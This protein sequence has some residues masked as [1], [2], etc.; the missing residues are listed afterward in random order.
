MEEQVVMSSV[1]IALYAPIIIAV[2][3]AVKQAV[4]EK[5]GGIVTIAVAIGVGALLSLVSG[6]NVIE[7]ISS[8]LVAVGAITFKRAGVTK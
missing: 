1:E 7:G 4:P 3:E 2:V 5:L 6:L 8:A